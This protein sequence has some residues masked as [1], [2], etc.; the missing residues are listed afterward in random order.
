MSVSAHFQQVPR[1]RAGVRKRALAIVWHCCNE[2]SIEVLGLQSGVSTVVYCMHGESVQVCVLVLWC[3]RPRCRRRLWRC[4]LAVTR[5]RTDT[6]SHVWCQGVYWQRSAQS[7]HPESVP[8]S[9]LL[10]QQSVVYI[11]TLSHLAGW[12]EGHLH[13]VHL[14]PIFFLADSANLNKL[15]EKKAS[16]SCYVLVLILFTVLG[17]RI[18]FIA[19]IS[20][21][22]K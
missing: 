5:S 1:V 16:L 17:H 4:N 7:C 8:V 21:V 2:E 10:V 11:N 3:V 20:W 12:Q 22:S 9:V 18:Q 6:S 14:S 19:S 15:W 13:L